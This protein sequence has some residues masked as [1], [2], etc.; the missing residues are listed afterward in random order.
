MG[1]TPER[2]WYQMFPG[3][4]SSGTRQPH[5]ICGGVPIEKGKCSTGC[6]ISFTLA[7]VA[8]GLHVRLFSRERS[9]LVEVAFIPACCKYMGR[10]LAG[11]MDMQLQNHVC[12]PY[13]KEFI[14]VRKWELMP[15]CQS[16]CEI[17]I[18]VQNRFCCDQLATAV[19]LAVVYLSS[20]A[21]LAFAVQAL[22]VLAAIQPLSPQC[23]TSQINILYDGNIVWVCDNACQHRNEASWH[24]LPASS[25][26]FSLSCSVPLQQP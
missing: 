4:S 15:V 17:S 16:A 11:R 23:Y 21:V 18:C 6:N 26:S 14:C 3:A 25:L 13:T 1:R 10:A 20:S 5:N 19:E 9:E 7:I 24:G 22:P 2:G 8:S 12:C